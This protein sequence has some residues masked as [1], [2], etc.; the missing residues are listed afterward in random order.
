MFMGVGRLSPSHVMDPWQQDQD[1]IDTSVVW[2]PPFSQCTTRPAVPAQMRWQWSCS[3]VCVH[4]F[5]IGLGFTDTAHTH[6]GGHWF[7]LLWRTCGPLVLNN[8]RITWKQPSWTNTLPDMITQHHPFTLIGQGSYYWG[9]TFMHRNTRGGVKKPTGIP[10]QFLCT[11]QSFP[12]SAFYPHVV[13]RI[14]PAVL[15]WLD[16]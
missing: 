8:L 2:M 10:L 3:C 7:V 14:I 9:H 16:N 5:L 4:L 6:G 13:G 12:E 15:W 11:V 1:V